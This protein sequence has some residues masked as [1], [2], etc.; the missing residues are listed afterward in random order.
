M[1]LDICTELLEDVRNGWE[2][3]ELEAEEYTEDGGYILEML[4]YE[5]ETTLFWC[6]I[7]TSKGEIY[8]GGSVICESKNELLSYTAR[9]LEGLCNQAYYYN[10]CQVE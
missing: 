7:I 2:Y 3:R 5:H 10:N 4:K 6:E 9:F 1:L 8:K